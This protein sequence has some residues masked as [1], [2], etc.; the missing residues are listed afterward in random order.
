MDGVTFVEQKFATQMVLLL[1]LTTDD[2]GMHFVAVIGRLWFFYAAL[3]GKA[4]F[5]DSFDTSSSSSNENTPTSSP[6]ATITPGEDAKSGEKPMD[7][8]SDAKVRNSSWPLPGQ[9]FCGVLELSPSP[10]CG[11]V[12][13][14]MSAIALSEA[15]MQIDNLIYVI[16]R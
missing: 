9:C 15:T 8:G 16:A 6:R 10:C 3:P 11:A 4:N 5:D 7:I 13:W 1:L 12:N 14:V 2:R